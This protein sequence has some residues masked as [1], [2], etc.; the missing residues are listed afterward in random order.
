MFLMVGT[1]VC[2][3][4]LEHGLQSKFVVNAFQFLNKGICNHHFRI[5]TSLCASIAVAAAGIGHIAF[6]FV[7]IQQGVHYIHFTLLVKQGDE[8]GGGAVGVPD[9]IIVIIV[10]RFR[11]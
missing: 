7:D 9:G 4:I 11:P 2:I 5:G 1:R 8:W 6:P 10:G 3:R